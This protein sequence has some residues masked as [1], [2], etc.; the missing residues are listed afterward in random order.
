[1]GPELIRQE[2]TNF[3]GNFTVTEQ[4]VVHIL[5]GFTSEF[6]TVIDRKLAQF[7]TVRFVL[8]AKFIQICVFFKLVKLISCLL[9]QV[10]A[11]ICYSANCLINTENC[12]F[13]F[14][15]ILDFTSQVGMG[16]M[17]DE[18]LLRIFYELILSLFP[19]N[20]STTWS[21]EKLFQALIEKNTLDSEIDPTLVK[22][23]S[24]DSFEG[25]Q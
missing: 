9:K 22:L 7:G 3:T 1:M 18:N 2:G 17:A 16:R 15:F 13:F 6:G 5:Y 4:F 12:I 10:G 20:F 14:K 24:S 21:T 19:N 23:R 11:K 25:S 8:S